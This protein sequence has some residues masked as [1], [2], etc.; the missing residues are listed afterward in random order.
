[1]YFDSM[2]VPLWAIQVTQL[3]LGA[4]MV[5][6]FWRIC[7][8]PGIP[9]RVVALDLLGSLIMAQL[10]VLA[11]QHRFISYLDVAAA[12]AII[13]FLATIAFARYLEQQEAQE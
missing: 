2:T 3:L 11:I 7:R 4:A 5:L 1:M 9:D 6:T 10:V 8:G 13:S 12:I